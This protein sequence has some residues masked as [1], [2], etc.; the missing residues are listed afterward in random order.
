MSSDSQHPAQR[1]GYGQ[2][3]GQ[4]QTARVLQQ[5]QPRAVILWPG[6]WAARR[7]RQAG[8]QSQ[9][10]YARG[11]R[12]AIGPF[13]LL[14][15]PGRTAGSTVSNYKQ[16]KFREPS[17]KRSLKNREKELSLSFPFFS[18]PNSLSLALDIKYG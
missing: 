9:T 8:Q 2:P 18:T 12:E 16:Q 13:P 6:L 17:N 1:Q 11:E 15:S 7:Q 10:K 14:L 5:P 4:R 3:G